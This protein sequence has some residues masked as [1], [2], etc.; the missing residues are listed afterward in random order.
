MANVYWVRSLVPREKNCTSWASSSAIITEAGV[1]IITPIS[2]SPIGTPWVFSS[3]RHSSRISLA[4]RT[5]RTEMIMGNMMDTV[6]KALARRIARSWVLNT[7]R[8]VRQ[9]RMAR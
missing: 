3:A 2:T 9:M 5:S 6:P 7:S 8:R 1:S 4:S